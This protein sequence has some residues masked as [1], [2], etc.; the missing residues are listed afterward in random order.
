MSES[1]TA[2]KISGKQNG[3]FKCGRGTQKRGGGVADRDIVCGWP[4]KRHRMSQEDESGQATRK[5]EGYC[6]VSGRRRLLVRRMAM[7]CLEKVQSELGQRA[8]GA[9]INDSLVCD[10]A[11]V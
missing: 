5:R 2:V 10:F 11:V 7:R 8:M 1:D 9:I 4:C 6:N 3:F